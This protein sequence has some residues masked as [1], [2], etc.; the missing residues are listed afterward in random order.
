MC[1][2]IMNRVRALLA[3][4][5]FVITGFLL[6]AF[7]PADLM[8]PLQMFRGEIFRTNCLLICTFDR[9]LV[10]LDIKG[11]RLPE[12]SQNCVTI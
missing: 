6:S 9:I 8:P 5:G 10:G 7:V 12:L 1:I 2:Y 4:I 11:D 3:G